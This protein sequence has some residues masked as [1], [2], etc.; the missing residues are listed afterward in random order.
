MNATARKADG[1]TTYRTNV[2]GTVTI[3]RPGGRALNTF[4]TQAAAESFAA[5]M[6][7]DDDRAITPRYA[8]A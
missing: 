5:R 2:D 1:L 8:T 4:R 6:W 7:S 3:V